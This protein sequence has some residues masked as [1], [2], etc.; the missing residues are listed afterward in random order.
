M[1]LPL[2]EL[3]SRG[4]REC[5]VVARGG[6]ELTRSVPSGPKVLDRHHGKT[7]SK[8]R[9]EVFDTVSCA[10][11]WIGRLPSLTPRSIL[12]EHIFHSQRRC[13]DVYFRPSLF[14][15][16]TPEAFTR[17]NSQGV[18]RGGRSY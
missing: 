6:A 18:R 10:V 16:L 9:K 14:R 15:P 7:L 1:A 17:A 11:A 3:S 5:L 13:A 12:S 2:G 8:K 4:L